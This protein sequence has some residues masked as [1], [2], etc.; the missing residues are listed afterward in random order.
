[1]SRKELLTEQLKETVDT[2]VKYIDVD[3]GNTVRKSITQTFLILNNDI[4]I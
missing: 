4:Q 3:T 1:M 2:Y